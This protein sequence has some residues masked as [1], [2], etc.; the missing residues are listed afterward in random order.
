MVKAL[1]STRA[2]RALGSRTQRSLRPAS[3]LLPL[4]AIVLI[5]APAPVVLTARLG[6][7][8]AGLA[9]ALI[10]FALESSAAAARLTAVIAVP[11]RYV[12]LAAASH[13]GCCTELSLEQP[14]AQ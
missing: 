11:G 6:S 8:A 9:L 2:S 4:L 1:K 5:S 13:A 7:V 3:W 10:F 12:S 14:I